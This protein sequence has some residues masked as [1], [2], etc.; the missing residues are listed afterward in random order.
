MCTL[1][2]C[3]IPL[4][5]QMTD[6]IFAKSN[7][8]FRTDYA[9]SQFFHSNRNCHSTF[10]SRIDIYKKEFFLTKLFVA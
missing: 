9:E 3:K 10:N 7:R 4:K 8:L 2:K 1:V 6:E 5:Q